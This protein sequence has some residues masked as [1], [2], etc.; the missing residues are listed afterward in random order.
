MLAR[1]IERPYLCFDL[2]SIMEVKSDGQMQINKFIAKNW[3]NIFGKH[4]FSVYQNLTLE[5]KQ[6]QSM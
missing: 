6:T 2:N 3:E 5:I 1:N 4:P